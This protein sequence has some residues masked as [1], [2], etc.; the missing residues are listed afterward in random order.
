MG[1][2]TNNKK[3]EIIRVEKRSNY[4]IIDKGFLENP[5]LSFKAKGVLAYLLSRPDNWSTF[6]PDLVNKSTDGRSA[7]Y[8]AL[9]ELKALGYYKRERVR[10]EKT[11]KFTRWENV[12]YETPLSGFPYMDNPDMV[13]PDMDYPETE[14][15]DVDFPDVEN[16]D[17]ELNNNIINNN[18]Q[19]S[20]EKLN[21]EKIK[22]KQI[23]NDM[24]VSHVSQSYD[25]DNDGQNDI[26]Q[27]V[28]EFKRQ[29]SYDELVYCHQDEREMLDEIVSVGVDA[30]LTQGELVIDG[31]RKP[32][33]LVKYHFAN[34]KYQHIEWVLWQ[35]QKQSG[36]IKNKR[37]YILT[38]LYNVSMELNLEFDNIARN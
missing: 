20:N 7:V 32:S 8:S 34:L 28:Y 33:S 14:L 15:P 29:I 10:D 35:F 26:M 22:P 3:G 25:K 19:L 23:K 38:S 36:R 1:K 6:V 11:G 24:S 21:N 16:A 12:I 13:F 27:T 17:L 18:K 30:I 2:E 5:N 9:R 37:K 31:E 4:A